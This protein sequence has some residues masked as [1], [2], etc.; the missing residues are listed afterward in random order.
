MHSALSSPAFA[1]L[2]AQRYA[3]AQL[4]QQRE[5]IERF[6][7]PENQA[8]ISG[9]NHP[10]VR[11]GADEIA[12][13]MR[14]HTFLTRPPVADPS[15]GPDP[16]PSAGRNRRHFRCMGLMMRDR[17]RDP[18][19]PENLLKLSQYRD[20]LKAVAESVED[21]LANGPRD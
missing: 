13:G 10:S 8:A 6:N 16:P 14:A 12:A 11:T 21:E 18:V 15:S 4:A 7:T 19:P 3:E 20:I 17:R 5:L 1:A 2:L 9:F